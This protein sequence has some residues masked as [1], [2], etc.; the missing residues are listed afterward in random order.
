[1]TAWTRADL[2]RFAEA[3]ELTIQARRPEGGLRAPV[4]IWVVHDDGNL[5][6]RSYK[7]EDAAWYRAATT[8]GTGRVSAGGVEADVDVTKETDSQVNDRVDAAYRTK[9]R[10][11]GASYVGPMT[12]ATA[13]ATTLKITPAAGPGT[14]GASRLDHR[15]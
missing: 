4:P 5:S 9:Y 3:T 2:T 13:R 14:T 10:A 12:S 1:M 15:L 11:Y 7:G 6:I 8:T